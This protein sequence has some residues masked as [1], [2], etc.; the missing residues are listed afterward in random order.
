MKKISSVGLYIL[1]AS[2][3]FAANVRAEESVT[4]KEETEKNEASDSAKRT[5]REVEDQACPLVNGKIVCLEKKIKHTVKNM[6]DSEKTKAKEKN[7]SE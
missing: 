2:L 6:S 1:A 3:G 7:K 5:Y 4:K